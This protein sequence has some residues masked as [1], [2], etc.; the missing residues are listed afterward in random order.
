MLFNHRSDSDSFIKYLRD[1]GMK[2]GER[3]T[4]FSPET[5]EIDTTRPYMINIGNDVQITKGVTIL[6]HV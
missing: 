1:K 6:T 3:V 4:F 2:I 5:A